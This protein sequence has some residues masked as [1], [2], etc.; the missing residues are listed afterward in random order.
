MMPNPLEGLSEESKQ[1]VFFY[2]LEQA[3]MKASYDMEGRATKLCPVDTGRLRTTLREKFSIE[4]DGKSMI[5]ITMIAGTD[6]AE[7]VEYGTSRQRPQ[8]FIRPAIHTFINYYLPTRI[9]EV[10]SDAGIAS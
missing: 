4:S 8:P 6:Y 3:V 2:L 7:F 1:E 5:T 10:F 9:K